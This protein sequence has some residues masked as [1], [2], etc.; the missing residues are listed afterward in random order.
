MLGNTAGLERC[1]CGVEVRVGGRIGL[2]EIGAGNAERLTGVKEVGGGVGVLEMAGGGGVGV[3][4]GGGTDGDFGRM[5]C[6]GSCAIG[7]GGGRD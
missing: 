4:V 2:G 7:G 6:G 3:A 1:W 5:E